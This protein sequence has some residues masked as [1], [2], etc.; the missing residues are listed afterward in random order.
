MFSDSG[1]CMTEALFDEFDHLADLV[2]RLGSIPP[3]RPRRVSAPSP[4]GQVSSIAWGDGPSE[5]SFFHGGGL[6]AH[7]WDATIGALG[8]PALAWDLP[9][10]GESEWRD[11][12]DYRPETSAETLGFVLGSLVAKPQLLVGHSWGGLTA[13]ELLGRSP[14]LVRALVLVDV[15]PGVEPAGGGGVGRFMDGPAAFDSREQ[16]VERALAHGI[17][18][19]RDALERGVQLNT[20]VRADGKIVYKHH[21]SQMPADQRIPPW[22]AER[23][24]GVLEAAAVPL[25]LVYGNR[26][27]VG[28]ERA[29]RFLDRVPG[30]QAIRVDAEHNVHQQAPEQFAQILAEFA[31]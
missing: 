25:L 4:N 3:T 8:R 16:I 10:H 23:C 5:F 30:S 26:G 12:A 9:G 19:S 31:A 13:I 14:D 11:D 29:R 20:R 17:G 6:N 15:T 7:S 18:R 27:Y 1:I 28:E 22:N 21:F 2:Q 24:W